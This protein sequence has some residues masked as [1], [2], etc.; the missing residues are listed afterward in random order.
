[1]CGAGKIKNIPEKGGPPLYRAPLLL[2]TGCIRRAVAVRAAAFPGGG[3]RA[4]FGELPFINQYK[5]L[6]LN[7]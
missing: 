6:S 2:G 7:Q 5:D 3:I 1:M 4:S